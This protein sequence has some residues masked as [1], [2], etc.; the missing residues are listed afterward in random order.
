MAVADRLLT[1]PCLS[2]RS[3][4]TAGALQPHALARPQ[5]LLLLLL[6]FL[7]LRLPR[8]CVRPPAPLVAAPACRSL[9]LRHP[10]SRHHQPRATAHA[11]TPPEPFSS[12]CLPA[13]PPP[14]PHA[15]LFSQFFFFPS[16]FPRVSDVTHEE[17][18]SLL[19]FLFEERTS[20]GLGLVRRVCGGNRAA[21]VAQDLDHGV[22]VGPVVG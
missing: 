11:F 16:S 19:S 3:G 18:S 21:L 8:A 7:R 17:H 12:L 20:W 22:D 2:A 5:P 1:A 10:A 15:R 14:S 9:R 6:L 4:L 13:R